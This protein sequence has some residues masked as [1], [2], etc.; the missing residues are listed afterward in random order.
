VALGSA[1]GGVLRYGL[2]VLWPYD[3]ATQALPIATI[4]INVLGSLLVGWVFAASMPGGTLELNVPAVMF[5]GAGLAGG[6]TTFSLF[7]LE[8]F[9]LLQIGEPL[10][11]LTQV[12]IAVPACL[13]AVAAGYLLGR[14]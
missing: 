8:T 9:R 7:S 3:P 6:F 12:A 5:L 10:T 2:G 11:A 13:V 14:L 4:T 1:L